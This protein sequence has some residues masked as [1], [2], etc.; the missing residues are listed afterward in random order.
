MLPKSLLKRVARGDIELCNALIGSLRKSSKR[1]TSWFVRKDNAADKLRSPNLFL[2]LVT[3]DSVGTTE[4]ATVVASA[5]RLLRAG[6]LLAR[7][8]LAQ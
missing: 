5:S 4:R 8:L 3:E 7:L 1:N 2:C 6:L